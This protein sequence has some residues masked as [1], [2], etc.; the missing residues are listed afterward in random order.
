MGYLDDL[1]KSTKEGSLDAKEKTFSE[2]KEMEVK[3]L[4]EQTINR[5]LIK[6]YGRVKIYKYEGDP[7]LHYEVPVPK[8][9]GQ[10][11]RII[12]TIKTLATK[13]ITKSPDE[14]ATKEEVWDFYYNKVY[15]IINAAAIKLNIPKAK[16]DFYA[17]WVTREMIGYG[18]L[19]ILTEDDLLEEIMVN[20]P[21]RPVYVYHREMR[22]LKTNIIF[23]SDE[24]I[25]AIVE[26]IA[27]QIGR[28]IDVQ[29]PLLDATL[30]DGSRVNATIPPISIDGCSVTIRKFKKDPFTVLDL[31][32]FGTINSE[33]AA[34]LWLAVE[35]VGGA[36]PGNILIAGGTGSGKTSTLNVLASFTPATER[37]ITVEDTPELQLPIE[38]VIRL[39]TRPP[40][41]EGTGEVTM[42][43]LV[44]N[45]LRMRPDR[46]IVGEVRD[47]EA[48]T[49]FTAMNTGHDGALTPD[50]PIFLSDGKIIEIGEFVDSFF[51]ELPN[52]IKKYK[53]FEFLDINDENIYIKSMN[54][55]T[56]KFE[57]K[58][59]TKLWRTYKKCKLIKIK[60]KS[61][62]E[63]VLTKD[64]PV[65]ILDN[66]VIEINAEFLRKGDYIAL[67]RK[68][69]TLHFERKDNLN[70]NVDPYVVGF[71]LGDGHVRD[72]HIEFVDS[73][74][75]TLEGCLKRLKDKCSSYKFKEFN[76]YYRLIIHGKDVSEIVSQYVPKGNKTKSFKVDKRILL[77]GDKTIAL[78]LKGLFDADSHVNKRT[79]AIEFVT[80]NKHLAEI[81]PY[82]LLRFDIFSHTS[83]NKYF[84]IQI[85]GKENLLKFLKNIGFCN[86]S[87]LKDLKKIIEKSGFSMDLV[88]NVDKLIKLARIKTGLTQTNLA[89]MLD[90][91]RSVVSSYE[92]NIRKP[93]RKN[94]E[95]INQI[96]RDEK[97]KILIE[98]DVI[99]DKI[100]DIEYIDYEGYLY[101]LTVEDNHTYIA[102]K[103]GGLV[104]SNCLGTI[105]A[106]N[107][108]ETFVRV[109]SEPM[110]VPE[111]MVEALD[112]VIVQNRINDRRK[113]AIRRIV[114]I[115]ELESIIDKKPSTYLLYEWDAYSDTIHRTG[116]PSKYIQKIMKYTGLSKTDIEDEIENRK[117]FL[118]SLLEKGGRLDIKQFKKELN[119]YE[120]LF[121]SK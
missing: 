81:L 90:I 95:R 57:D 20:G 115:G 35:G 82:L 38:H 69:E 85:C 4:E 7:I 27:R 8:M 91:S 18:A 75:N 76:T 77:S 88:P 23:E 36:K 22:M 19:D 12:N 9:K 99:W 68:L 93:R 100:V 5:I 97:L 83:K 31:I 101:D 44:K 104:V 21:K 110:N 25:Y 108:T 107:T 51:D 70:N 34:F 32:K 2:V 55:K 118:E 50:M 16:Y 30:R 42:D 26:R 92:R 86:K 46:I 117:K 40:S 80:S 89:K 112:L 13:V 114:E 28:R 61:G 94:L 1:V 45:T 96:L 43:M 39:L 103:Y 10:E 17:E 71:C 49:L 98:G 59:I 6:E 74:R 84:K 65:Y 72:Y 52:K 53:E 14:F 58:K 41:L 66:S 37:V 79:N 109:M 121:K 87:K 47:K 64:H 106:N 62:K 102:G 54:K 73:D 63:I 24:D 48:S 67:P 33:V 113:G 111:I 11:R 116:M 60:T 3:P 120:P 15:E 119:K 29:S 78:F 56:L 105:H